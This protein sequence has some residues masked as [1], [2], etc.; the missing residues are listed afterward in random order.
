MNVAEE[1]IVAYHRFYPY[2]KFLMVVN[3][4]HKP[5]QAFPK[6]RMFYSI[7]PYNVGGNIFFIFD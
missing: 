7:N 1:M 6:G 2:G 3:F 4:M 5:N